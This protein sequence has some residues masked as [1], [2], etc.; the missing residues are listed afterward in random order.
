M[1]GD[2]S[3]KAQREGTPQLGLR[4]CQAGGTSGGDRRL[5]QVIR[6]ICIVTLLE[7]LNTA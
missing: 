3:E 5:D 1:Q 7:R 4:G 2:P 6:P